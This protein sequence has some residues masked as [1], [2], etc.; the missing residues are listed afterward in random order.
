MIALAFM[1]A[2]VTYD[3]TYTDAVGAKCACFVVGQRE[4]CAC[5]NGP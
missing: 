1:L 3:T 5:M 4:A 2:W